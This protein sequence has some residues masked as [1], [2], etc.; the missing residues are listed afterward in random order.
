LSKL[1]NDSINRQ[2]IKLYWQ[3]IRKYK[4]SFFTAVICIPLSATLIDA[5]LPFFLS[6]TISQAVQSIDLSQTTLILA[7]VTGLV[8]VVLNFIGFRALT[9]H[10]SSSQKELIE[11]TYQSLIA[12]DINFFINTKLGALTSRFTDFIGSEVELRDLLVIEST[13][14]VLSF[15]TGIAILFSQMWQ[16]AVV[17]LVFISLLLLEIY[18]S[19]NKRKAWRKTRRKTRSRMYGDL[20]DSLTNSIAVKTFASEKLEFKNLQKHTEKYRQTY[21]KD[22][23]FMSTEGS[24]RVF[25]M[26]TIQVVTVGYLIYLLSHNH[27]ELSVAIFVLAYLQQINTQIFTIGRILQSFDNALLDASPMTEILL[28]A[29]Q[30][31]DKKGA[32]KIEVT[33]GLIE[34]NNLSYVYD[35]KKELALSDIDLVIK[36]GQKIGLVGKSGS[37]KTTLVNLLLRFFDPTIGEIRIDGQNIADIKQGSLR[38]QIAFVPQ[39]PLLFHRSLRENIAYGRPNASEKEIINAAKR[40]NAWEFIKKLPDGL[41][42]LVGERGIKLS[43]G[44]RQRIAIARAILKDAPILLLDEATSA[45][46]SESEKLIQDSLEHLMHQRTSIV[47]AHRL[48]TIAKLDRII[49]LKD[50]KVIED[51]THRQLIKNGKTYARLWKH[52]S[53]GF[54]DTVD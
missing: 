30:I 34:F 37:G 44:Q 49:V 21:L 47:I 9:F 35:G 4:A 53:G 25:I 15:A 29:D 51:G 42:T 20:A 17:F 8:G 1:K 22:I 6:K 39:E 36:P 31:K 16:L 5:L 28:S 14:F 19:I 38:E 7:S 40:A 46:D 10:E 27:I 12:K 26:T 54:I 3:Q 33:E 24:V 48:S 2:T 45:L 50:G 43:G 18:W 52:Q 11:N 13:G 32:R 23:G 41:D